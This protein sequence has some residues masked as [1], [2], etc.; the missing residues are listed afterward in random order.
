MG[1]QKNP[2]TALREKTIQKKN[3]EKEQRKAEAGT[4]DPVQ[5]DD[6]NA[7]DGTSG[8]SDNKKARKEREKAEAKVAAEEAERVIA[9]E[10]RKEQQKQAKADAKAK[11]KADAKAD[12]EAKAAEAKAAD[13]KAKLKREEEELKKQQD[14]KKKKEQQKVAVEQ[15][16]LPQ[17]K[18][19]TPRSSVDTDGRRKSASNN[20]TN[21]GVTAASTKAG[22]QKRAQPAAQVAQSA[23]LTQGT[24]EPQRK[25]GGLDNNRVTSQDMWGLREKAALSLLLDGDDSREGSRPQQSRPQT[26]GFSSA[27]GGERMQPRT[28]PGLA[29]GNPPAFSSAIGGD[30]IGGDIIWQPTRQQRS[31]NRGDPFS[32][33]IGGST[34]GDLPESPPTTSAKPPHT[35]LNHTSIPPANDPF[36][37]GFNS[38]RGAPPGQQQSSFFD[39]TTPTDRAGSFFASNPFFAGQAQ[40]QDSSLGGSLDSPSGVLSELLEDDDSHNEDTFGSNAFP[41]PPRADRS[42]LSPPG[43]TA[44]PFGS[45]PMMNSSGYGLPAAPGAGFGQ[46]SDLNTNSASFRPPNSDLNTNSAPFAPPNKRTQSRFGFPSGDEPN[47]SPGDRGPNFSLFG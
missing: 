1:T 15:Y 38:R 3:G 10:K 22:Q 35:D 8:A 14:T 29:P 25:A 47:E 34:F 21:N 23:Q 44:Q 43:A 2:L 17:P 37:G 26:D 39:F 4:S 31:N 42:P 46:F 40:D 11:A 20:P 24:A 30:P 32:S 7:K 13:A 33:A 45:G 12:A 5:R 28:S 6:V 36:A 16:G 9:E 27:I 18:P 41:S 19:P